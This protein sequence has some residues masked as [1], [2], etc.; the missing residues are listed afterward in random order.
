VGRFDSSHTSIWH[1]LINLYRYRELVKQL[2]LKDLKLRYKSSILGF[3]WSLANPLLMMFV[4]YLVFVVLLPQTPP[5]NCDVANTRECRIY[6]SYTAFIL[7]GLLAWNFTANSISTG[8]MALLSHASM[9]KKVYFP[10]E[11]LAI[12]S[13]LAVFVN[14]LL[15]L[16]PLFLIIFIN[17]IGL[18]WY[19][20]LLPV[21]LFF[22]FMFICGVILFLSVAVVYFRDL[23]HIMEVAL[24]AWFFL[25]PILYTMDR[26][27]PS[28]QQLVYWLNP[29]ASFI[30]SYR[31]ILF[32]H[33]S[34]EPFFTLR[35]CLTG[36]LVFVLGYY[37]F[38]KA[39]RSLGEVL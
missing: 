26:V 28:A 13:V 10:R 25:T 9:I 24:T 8:M 2:T 5:Q 17:G 37:F 12:A 23:T 38:I 19:V 34:P 22:H 33:Y 6:N 15:S 7:V 27:F 30:E 21:I 4:F 32:F 39:S 11:T 3:L 16:I 1:S 31:A 29:M 36:V 35:T 18:T 14:F 20:L